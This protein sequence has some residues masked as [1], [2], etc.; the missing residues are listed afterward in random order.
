[1]SEES[2]FNIPTFPVPVRRALA[3]L[4]PTCVRAAAV[5]ILALTHSWFK[6]LF[7]GGVDTDEASVLACEQQLLE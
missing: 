6:A 4:A 7:N 1:M 3:R 2:S 5:L